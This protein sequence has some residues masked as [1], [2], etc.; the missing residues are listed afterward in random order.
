MSGIAVDELGVNG[1]GVE[2]SEEP[3]HTHSTCHVATAEQQD[4][5][6][7]PHVRAQSHASMCCFSFGVAT[8]QHTWK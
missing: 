1:R 2:D 4:F 3:L 7:L 8:K 6:K 5:V